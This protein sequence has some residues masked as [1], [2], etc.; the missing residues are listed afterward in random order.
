[1]A[2]EVDNNLSSTGFIFNKRIDLSQELNNKITL[3]LERRLTAIKIDIKYK[4]EIFLFIL[5]LVDLLNLHFWKP[6]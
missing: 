3:K 6:T 1:M 4:G 2:H 5:Q